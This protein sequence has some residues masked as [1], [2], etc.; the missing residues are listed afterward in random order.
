M[1]YRDLL[2]FKDQRIVDEVYKRYKDKNEELDQVYNEITQS[3]QTKRQTA[4]Y[5]YMQIMDKVTQ[6]MNLIGM[7]LFVILFV[8]GGA[9]I[10]AFFGMWLHFYVFKGSQPELL[11]WMTHLGANIYDVL[12]ASILGINSIEAV[13]IEP[14]VVQM[15]YILALTMILIIFF[16]VV[17]VISGLR[18]K[19]EVQSE[20][21]N[22]EIK[23]E[24][25]QQLQKRIE[26]SYHC[27]RVDEDDSWEYIRSSFERSLV[28]KNKDFYDRYYN[29]YICLFENY[30]SVEG[31]FDSLQQSQKVIL[32]I[33]T[34]LNS[35]KNILGTLSKP[36]FFSGIIV[37]LCYQIFDTRYANVLSLNSLFS[38]FGIG[39]IILFFIEKSYQIVISTPLN[40]IL[41]S[42]QVNSDVIKVL[43]TSIV[44]SC[45]YVIYQIY[46]NKIRECQ[47]QFQRRM[48]FYLK[49]NQGI[50]DENRKFSKNYLYSLD[51]TVFVVIIVIYIIYIYLK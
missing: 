25:P 14:I 45:V 30:Q 32:C 2:D 19:K 31:Q 18:H 11:Q 38:G 42:I 47:R 9:L 49:K 37:V 46:R 43:S 12:L 39:R 20:M 44:I 50:Y 23:E 35:I 6:I 7:I 15:F 1:T 24:T 36:I 4:Q 28:R 40:I 3:H 48:N 41:E 16:V 13:K 17:Y 26:R 29:A 10:L 5:R 27:L 21:I 51:F 33:R 22:E 34:L 8:L